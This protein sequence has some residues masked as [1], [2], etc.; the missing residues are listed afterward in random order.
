MR[1][2]IQDGAG[3][4]L[5][6]GTG[7]FLGRNGYIITNHHVIDEAEKVVADMSDGRKVSI[8]GVLAEDKANDIAILKTDFTP[9]LDETLALV[10]KGAPASRPG[11]RIFVIGAPIGLAG[12]L[13]EGIVSALRPSRD[14]DKLTGE[15]S[16]SR[17]DL[18]QITAAISPGSSGSP[19]INT[20]GEVV[21]V[22]ASY[23]GGGQSLNFAVPASVVHKLLVGI[24]AN[25]KPTPFKSTN[26]TAVRNIIISAVFFVAVA[27]AFRYVWQR[28]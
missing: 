21:G 17:E 24:T 15:K 9:S 7:F 4:E 23:F 13:S 8:L 20:S 27:F 25:T 12:T 1:L 28:I 14:I 16:T 26:K 22:A 11:D 3:R 19:V 6:T 10:S 18:L 5:G 2:Q